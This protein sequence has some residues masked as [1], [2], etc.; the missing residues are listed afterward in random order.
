MPVNALKLL[1]WLDPNDIG[2]ITRLDSIHTM[3]KVLVALVALVA[4]S[5]YCPNGCSGH[6][7]CLQ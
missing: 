5:A 1:R 2:I 6:G 4:V 3:S 7:S